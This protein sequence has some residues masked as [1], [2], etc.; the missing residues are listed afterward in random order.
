MSTLWTSLRLIAAEKLL[1][2]AMLLA[3]K[4]IREG[5]D[6]IAAVRSYC[7]SQ[8]TKTAKR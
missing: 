4:N 8:L 5:Q 1:H 7:V 2:L 6:L 3:P